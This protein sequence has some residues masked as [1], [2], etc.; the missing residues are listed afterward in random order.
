MTGGRDRLIRVWEIK[1]NYKLVQLYRTLKGHTSQILKLEISPDSKIL[2][3]I[4]EK[5]LRIWE[6][7]GGNQAM[8]FQDI[9]KGI[10]ALDFH[11]D[12]HQV[13]ISGGSGIIQIFDL[14]AKKIL[15][16]IE[17][18]EAV[19]DILYVNDGKVLVVGFDYV[20]EVDN[21]ILKVNFL[22]I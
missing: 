17:A 9:K 21:P 19:N 10:R 13:G 22:I 3:S 20:E 6:I 8:K 14:R 18:G 16:E 11:P 7:E 4:C 15:R 5:T 12:G 2:A 1:N